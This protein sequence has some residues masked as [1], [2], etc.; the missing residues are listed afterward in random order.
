MRKRKWKKPWYRAEGSP[1]V[2]SLR[3]TPSA[4][5]KLESFRDKGASEIG[6]FGITSPADKLLVLEFHTVKQKASAVSVAFEDEA[7]ADF[8]DNQADLGRKPDSYGRIWCHTHPGSSAMPS[9]VDEA[10]FKR[11]FGGCDWALMFILARGGSLE[12]MQLFVEF[13]GREPSID[14]LLRHS[15]LSEEAA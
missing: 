6:G 5:A 15:G 4:W 10:T 11:V 2:Q 8:F 12:P 14:A 9:S 3:F 1:R 13:R 7:V